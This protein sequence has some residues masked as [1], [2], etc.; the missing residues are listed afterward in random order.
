MSDE[1]GR[2]QGQRR[3]VEYFDAIVKLVENGATILA[4]LKSR[5]EFPS[6]PSFSTVLK[7]RPDLAHRYRQA[8]RK[9]QAGPNARSRGADYTR[10]EIDRA[11]AAVPR[12][13]EG[14]G[15]H[16]RVTAGGPHVATLKYHADRSQALGVEL[17]AA[18]EKRSFAAAAERNV[19]NAQR[20]ARSFDPL[21]QA[22]EQNPAYR[23]ASAAVPRGLDPDVKSDVIAD[24]CCA[25]AAGELNVQDIKATARRF[26][27]AHYRRFSPA[28]FMSLDGPSAWDPDVAIVDTLTTQEF[29]VD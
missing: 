5:P 23:A 19:E 28:K 4:A 16:S 11:I 3:V 27:E 29:Y 7:A 9:R 18:Y 13:R 21:A 17:R 8:S 2:R 6:Y 15:H 26:L 12:L 24:I 14:S 1:F 22:L 25:V 20:S 10:A